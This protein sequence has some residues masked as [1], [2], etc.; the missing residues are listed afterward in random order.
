MSLQ[1][2]RVPLLQEEGGHLARRC[3]KRSQGRTHHVEREEVEPR[4][5]E[6]T[7]F[8]VTSGQT[9]PLHATITVN[10]SPLSMVIDIGASVSI[11]SMKT[12]ETIQQSEKT[13]ELQESAAKL[14]TYTSEPIRVCGSMVVQVEHDGQSVP[15]PLIIT[16][17]RGPTLLGRN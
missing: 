6:Y 8:Q 10:G 9:G 15:L 4:E 16:E 14:Q 13:L 17:G 12:F 3:R 11:A 5:E 2:I 1:R 7:M